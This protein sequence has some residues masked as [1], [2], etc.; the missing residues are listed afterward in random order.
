MVCAHTIAWNLIEYQ[1]CSVRCMLLLA[2]AGGLALAKVGLVS[3]EALRTLCAPVTCRL[4]TAEIALVASKLSLL[5]LG[6]GL[7]LTCCL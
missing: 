3:S 1:N 7:A 5:S 6:A 4:G 2:F